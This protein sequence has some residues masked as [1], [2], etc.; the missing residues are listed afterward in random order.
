MSESERFDSISAVSFKLPPFYVNNP[1][2][3]FVF[4]DQ[5]FL[6][7]N[8]TKDET[9]FAYLVTALQEDVA[10][11]VLEVISDPPAE[12]KYDAL[13]TALMAQFALK[14]AEMAAALL[15]LP[16][17][18]DQKPSQLLQHMISLH[19]P[20]EKPN[21]LVREIFLRQL[22]DDVRS[23]LTDKTNLDIHQLAT[24]ADKFYATSGQRVHSVGPRPVRPRQVSAKED[25]V[26]YYHSRF[27]DKAKNCRSPC[28]YNQGN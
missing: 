15:D 23:H 8:I 9:K 16:G 13:K 14:P 6:L 20:G 21:F 12:G 17:L 25:V 1:K 2:L 11:R 22:P 4:A 28:K 27:G 26:C 7:R 10:L 18:G 19:P 24:K 3:W 5:Q